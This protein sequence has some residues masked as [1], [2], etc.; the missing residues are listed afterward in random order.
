VL[1]NE[2]QRFRIANNC[3]LC[4]KVGFSGRL[5]SY[6]ARASTKNSER[7]GFGHQFAPYCGEDKHDLVRLFMVPR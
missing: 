6:L 2:S 4:R 7:P 5:R 3:L 1:G